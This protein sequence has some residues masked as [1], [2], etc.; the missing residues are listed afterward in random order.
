MM[1]KTTKKITGTNNLLKRELLIQ[2]LNN[3]HLFSE[4]H[5]NSLFMGQ[6]VDDS[7]YSDAFDEVINYKIMR[8][9]QRFKHNKVVDDEQ[10]ELKD[11]YK[12]FSRQEKNDYF[13]MLARKWANKKARKFFNQSVRRASAEASVEGDLDE[14]FYNLEEKANLYLRKY[15]TIDVISEKLLNMMD[16]M[17]KYKSELIEE[18]HGNEMFLRICEHLPS[19]TTALWYMYL[20]TACL[21]L[22][23]SKSMADDLLI[24]SQ[25]CVVTGM[26]EKADVTALI[27]PILW[28]LRLV[29]GS[30][31]ASETEINVEGAFSSF[32]FDSR[33]HAADFITS[34]FVKSIRDIIMILASYHLFPKHV[35]KD[36][37]LWLG[38]TDKPKNIP[39]AMSKITTC[40][41]NIVLMGEQIM[42]D[43]RPISEV[44]LASDPV[45]ATKVKMN[46]LLLNGHSLYFGLP[47][48]GKY[49]AIT[50]IHE[51]EEVID[52]VKSMKDKIGPYDVRMT[53]LLEVSS[54]LLTI[55]NEVKGRTRGTKRP[56]PYMVI[57]TGPPGIGKSSIVTL[58]YQLWSKMKGREFSQRHVFEKN[59]TTD[60]WD[61]YSADGTPIIHM[62]EIGSLVKELA[63][64]GHDKSAIELLSLAD[65]LPYLLNMSQTK[66][67]GCTFACPELIVIDTNDASLNLDVLVKN[68]AAFM[69]R[70][71]YITPSV[72]AENVKEGGIALDADKVIDGQDTMDKWLFT[73]TRYSP[74]NMKEVNVHHLMTQSKEDDVFKLMSV[75]S[76]DMEKH[77]RREEAVNAM[78]NE[79]WVEKN[80]DKIIAAKA[81]NDTLKG[82]I[83]D[84]DSLDD[85]KDFIEI[86]ET[87]YEVLEEDEIVDDVISI[88][89]ILD[90]DSMNPHIQ[91]FVRTM[92]N[93]GL[94]VDVDCHDPVNLPV[95]MQRYQTDHK[96]YASH[97]DQLN[98]VIS[99]IREL[100]G[101]TY[102]LKYKGITRYMSLF[103]LHQIYPTA[104]NNLMKSGITTEGS[105]TY[106]R[107]L[108]DTYYMESKEAV[109]SY[110]KES[111]DDLGLCECCEFG[112]HDVGKIGRLRQAINLGSRITIGFLKAFMLTLM[113]T[114]INSIYIF[115]DLESLMQMFILFWVTIM[116]VYVPF[117]GIFSLL[118]IIV[119]SISYGLDQLKDNA[120]EKVTGIKVNLDRQ[121][122]EVLTRFE[123]LKGFLLRS[124]TMVYRMSLAIGAAVSLAYILKLIAGFFSTDQ[125][126]VESNF[127]S[128]HS[129]AIK[130]RK[131]ELIYEMSNPTTRIKT[132]DE[133]IKVY[134][135]IKSDLERP[136]QTSGT[137]DDFKKTIYKNVRPFMLSTD[138][139]K[140]Q[141]YALGLKGEFALINKHYL[142]FDREMKFSFANSLDHVFDDTFTY[143]YN[144]HKI[145]V[146]SDVIDLGDDVVIIRLPGALKTRDI[147]E[148]FP[149]M[150][151][152]CDRIIAAIANDKVCVTDCDAITAT[153]GGLHRSFEQINVATYQWSKHCPGVCGLPIIGELQRGFVIL[154]IHSSAQKNDTCYMVKLNQVQICEGLSAGVESGFEP[155]SAPEEDSKFDLTDPASR[156]FVKYVDLGPVSYYGQVHNFNG[157][158]STNIELS[159]FGEEKEFIYDMFNILP[160]HEMTPFVPA[161]MK[162]GKNKAGKYGSPIT[163]GAVKLCAERKPLN[164]VSLKKAEDVLFNQIVTNLTSINVSRDKHPI[165]MET[166]INGHVDD[167]LSRPIDKS[168]S[169]GFGYPGKKSRYL[170]KHLIDDREVY[171]PTPVLYSDINLIFENYEHG[172]MTSPVFKAALKD[173]V[174]SVEKYNAFKTRVFYATPFPLLMVQK[175]VM[176]PLYTLML[177]HPTLFYTGL[178]IDMHRRGQLIKHDL[179]TFCL[180]HGSEVNISEGDYGSFDTGMPYEIGRS[181]CNLSYRLLKWL[182]YNDLQL[183]LVTGILTDLLHPR[184]DYF[185]DLIE[186]PGLQPSGKYATAEDNSLRNLLILMYIWYDN[187]DTKELNFFDYVLPRVYGDDFVGA[188]LDS[189]SKSYNNIVIRDGCLK[190]GLDF[191]SS[192]KGDVVDAFID[193]KD[194]SFLKRTFRLHRAL[195]REVACLHPS[196]LVKMLQ[197]FEPS[198][199]V[200]AVLQY[201]NICNSA[202]TEFFF[203]INYEHEFNVLYEY[204][205][206]RLSKKFPLATFNL[207][208]YQLL[209]SRYQEGVEKDMSL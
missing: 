171:E 162:P 80:I 125:W 103:C 43:G 108:M 100:L 83:F 132:A 209:L 94:F 111:R 160:P 138:M 27:V 29:F 167:Y 143:K 154:G 97:V 4:N 198:D 188:V 23:R 71:I 95:A 8:K 204:L 3:P 91:S 141:G 165:D 114:L 107:S 186:V 93:N 86:P 131:R 77:I 68:I 202:L 152:S 129:D 21:Q 73:A 75:L 66:D 190:M 87:K 127:V 56:T 49:D 13:D 124:Q 85:E 55:L 96:L 79:N 28:S 139:Y 156:S 172:F 115:K 92:L 54:K 184:V 159:I 149:K 10:K 153:D 11:P 206:V 200:G 51:T 169:G 208:S 201:E 90:V 196:S 199:S 179:V 194:M 53:A 18:L 62:S 67:K 52:I 63:K 19:A 181:T 170:E 161:M 40:V 134:S 69:R 1:T 99:K 6:K 191:T 81:A 42:F 32:L 118:I 45:H 14:E 74:V 60:Y 35:A 76:N 197:Y 203:W 137:L 189:V 140:R 37:T 39:E 117:F 41:A 64:L 182:G 20:M 185:G 33:A 174:R 65:S 48:K 16:N 7:E 122:S 24:I 146:K 147:T 133:K 25:F 142:D 116:S 180:A 58:V 155:F 183:M 5:P 192:A 187:P 176:S 120:K 102:A 121:Y 195:D 136:I 2:Q 101:A 123:D 151:M 22:Y 112:I 57:V 98:V 104:Y 148:H 30:R 126:K 78:F 31:N 61:G 145:I 207:F 12:K 205:L 166:V 175:S 168:K 150:N 36:L 59:A 178:S 164:P 47:E 84:I 46:E 82:S 135:N 157:N 38:K 34:H 89:N 130:L 177:E 88:D 109:E 173:E 119:S 26:Q 113:Y 193:V 17:Q 72:R 106:V 44:F 50:W 9:I 158:Q 15:C 144:V 105:F 163:V 128:T 110:I 70:G